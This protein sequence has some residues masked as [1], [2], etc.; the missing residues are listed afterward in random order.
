MTSR[1]I[2]FRA[3]A[4]QAIGMGDLM[5]LVHLSYYFEASGWECFF[6]IK[7]YPAA[8]RLV[9]KY[10]INNL[11]IMDRKLGIDD[12]VEVINQLIREIGIVLLFFEITERKLSDYR[13]LPP[14]VKKACVSFDGEILPDLDLV[15]DWDVEAEDFF[16]RESFPQTKFLLGPEYVIL[17][18][19]FDYELIK[20][21]EFISRP[22]KLLIC[23]GGSDEL[24]F[25]QKVVDVIIE[26]S[27]DV[28]LNIV[29][30]A[31]HEF[32]QGLLDSLVG[33][34]INFNIKQNITGMFDEYMSCDVAVG[35]GG[36]TSSEIVA[37]S[38]PAV[39][40]ATYSHQVARCIYFHNNGFIRYLGFRE[41]DKSELIDAI[42]YPI[43]PGQHNLF[44]T[45]AIIDSCNEIIGTRYSH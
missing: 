3:D 41:F 38:T 28:K 13:G 25:T 34:G 2:L 36:L 26:N 10:C 30:G 29:I 39:L 14:H 5:S 22:E 32:R 42:M 33:R 31:G 44:N 12:E 43:Q 17:P 20:E 18:H 23:M 37:T 8:I 6:L 9:E 27:I 35:A 15:V 19:E 16:E 4:S 7:D 1:K 45:R 11:H 40:I 24:N 21:R